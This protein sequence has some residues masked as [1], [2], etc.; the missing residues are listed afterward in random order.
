MNNFKYKGKNIVNDLRGVIVKKAIYII[1]PLF[2]SAILLILLFSSG[3]DKNPDSRNL[4]ILKS[5]NGKVA[6][7]ENDNA[8]P[9]NIYD[10]YIDSLPQA[11]RDQLSAG[12]EIESDAQ[13]Q[14]LLEDLDS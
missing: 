14:S 8:T 1:V 4:L 13:L 3:T 6:L 5:Y 12:I 7:Y 10:I 2:I 11:D 9:K